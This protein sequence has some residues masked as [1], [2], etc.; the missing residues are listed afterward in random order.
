MFSLRKGMNFEISMLPL[1]RRS[2]LELERTEE[3]MENHSERL[4]VEFDEYE[5]QNSSVNVWWVF[6]R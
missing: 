2:T 3:M 1:I 5:R 4:S 6:R